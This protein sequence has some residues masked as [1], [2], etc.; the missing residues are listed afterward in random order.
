MAGWLDLPLKLL[1]KYREVFN[2]EMH[3]DEDGKTISSYTNFL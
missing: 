2:L 3:H 1:E